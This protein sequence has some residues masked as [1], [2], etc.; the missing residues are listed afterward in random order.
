MARGQISSRRDGTLVDTWV[1]EFSG[2][3]P[4][5]TR[6]EEEIEE[7]VKK[8][9]PTVHGKKIKIELRLIKE[10]ARSERPPLAT[11]EVSF[12][13]LCKEA[14][15]EI[16]GTDIEALRVAVWDRLDKKYGTVWETYYLVEI[17]PGRTWEGIGT[18][19]NFSYKTVERGVA[20]DGTLLLREYD[21]GGDFRTS[22]YKVSPWPGEF[23]D[24]NG[25]VLACIPGGA[26]NHD[27]LTE[28]A[29]RIDALRDKLVDMVRP[30]RILHTLETLSTNNLLPPPKSANEPEEFHA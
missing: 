1:Y 12:K 22:P 29:R 24:K 2:L 7:G 6:T 27:A 18:G 8:P 30:E 13:V 28:F 11:K 3:A 16:E 15:I 23:R 9:A 17:A 25:T 20:W 21:R 5:D 26:K 14:N 4:E 19:L 10:F